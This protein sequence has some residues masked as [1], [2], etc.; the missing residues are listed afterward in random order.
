MA[1]WSNESLKLKKGHSWSA[2]SGYRI[3]LADRGAVRFNFPQDWTLEPGDDA[4]YFYDRKPPDDNCRLACSYLTLPP[5]E[6]SGLQLSDLMKAATEGDP[7]EL[8]MSGDM[9]GANRP[10]LEF[11]WA[12]FG[13]MDPME[14]RRA[15]TRVCIARGSNLQTLITLDYWDEDGARLAPI[16]REIIRSLQLGR[17]VSD[18]TTGDVIN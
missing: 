15:Y 8:R 17:Y 4:T 14:R 2:P 6:W 10:D 3:F 9:V 18:P 7:R 5:I 12:D 11:A 1:D 16:W 13:F